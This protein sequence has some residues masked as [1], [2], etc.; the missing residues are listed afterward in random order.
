MGQK[1]DLKLIKKVLKD[2]RGLYT[3]E[4]LMDMQYQYQLM[5]A[6]RKV[7]K[8]LKKQVPKDLVTNQTT[9]LKPMRPVKARDLLRLDPLMKVEMIKYSQS[10]TTCVYG[11]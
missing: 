3:E 7:K 5:K 2:R 9:N 6:Q 11:W 10:T 8:A 4:E 1:K